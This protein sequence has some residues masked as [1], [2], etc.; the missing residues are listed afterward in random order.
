MPRISA[1]I[2]DYLTTIYRLEEAL[3]E[4]K[5][6][7]ISRELGV[8]NATVSKII[9]R[10]ES[11]GLVIR[12]KYHRVTLTEK[13]REIAREI[14]RRHRIAELFL[15]KILGFNDRDAHYYAHYLEHLPSEIIER[16]Y[17]YLGKPS[18][19]PHGNP[20]VDYE[21]KKKTTLSEAPD[22][23]T[24]IV[25]RLLGELRIVLEYASENSIRVGS[26]IKILGKDSD[27]III[28]LSNREIQVP[29]RI[30]RLIVVE[31]SDLSS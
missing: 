11:R 8:S 27:T 7:D 9:S 29:R 30:A 4:A 23:K 6:S 3:G 25:K 10:L 22:N 2:E 17:E 16:I 18:T 20:V 21:L 31:C 24:C 1:R 13:G 28:E 19:C 26:S 14:I 12:E 15:A 5:T